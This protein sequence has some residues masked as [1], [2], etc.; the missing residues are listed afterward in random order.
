MRQ[1]GVRTVALA[2]IAAV[3]T[4]CVSDQ[5]VRLRYLP[6]SRIERLAGAQPVTVFRFADRRGSEGD[7]DPRRVG[8]I[9]DG[10]GSRLAKVL[11]AAP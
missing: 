7:H 1:S 11:S 3:F 5:T 9:Y 8:G 10:Y 4:A 2:M 6:D